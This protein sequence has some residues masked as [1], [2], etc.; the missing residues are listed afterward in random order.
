MIVKATAK[1][2]KTSPRKMGEVAA[3][4]RGRSVAD[5]LTILD[6]TPR[7]A[8]VLLKK[9]IKSAEANATNNHNLSAPL[10][11]DTLI[12]GTGPFMKRW[13]PAAFGRAHP[14]HRR[15]SHV[16]VA[17]KSTAEPKAAKPAKTKATAGSTGRQVNAAGEA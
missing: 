8:A 2:L 7:R 10:V 13:K 16:T 6:H 9:V 14:I 4:V 3:L 12:V 15:T 5:A 11:I 1:N 17:V